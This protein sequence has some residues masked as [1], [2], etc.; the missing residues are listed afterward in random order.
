MNFITVRD[1]RTQ[2]G[3]VWKN[4][5][6]SHEL[7]V[8]NNGKPSAL[9]ISVDDDDV[10]E[11]LNCVRQSLA[12]RAVN[13]LR[14]EAAKQKVDE[15]SEAEILNEIAETRAQRKQRRETT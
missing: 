9:M 6:A 4:L 12:M 2:P 7:I 11:V 14:M 15:L 8:T 10:E 13:K 1:L 3:Q 5:S